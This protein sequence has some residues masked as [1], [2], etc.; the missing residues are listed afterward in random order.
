MRRVPGLVDISRRDFCRLAGCAGA[1]ALTGCMD[2]NTGAVQTGGLG[3]HGNG[4]N[5]DGNT[6]HDGNGG[7]HDA[8]MMV[9]CT[10]TPTDVGAANSYTL[11][12]PKYFSGGFFVVK[13][14]TGFYA[15]SAACTHEGATLQGQTSQ[16]Y[17]P[18]HG[19]TFDFDGN[20]TGGPVFTGLVHYAMCD[21]G[22]GTLGVIKS[23]QVSQAT[24]LAG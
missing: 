22:T 14:A 8:N 24:R 16:F 15:L 3:G 17:C 23:Q 11:N 7:Q 13:D 18:R 2:G 1:L 5:P 4:H 6:G 21:T 19:A 9:A 20:A 10:S 12:T